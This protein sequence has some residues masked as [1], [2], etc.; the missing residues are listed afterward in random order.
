MSF[1]NLA[2]NISKS[3][4]T[5]STNNTNT[6]S[7]INSTSHTHSQ[8]NNDNDYDNRKDLRTPSSPLATF[9]TSDIPASPKPILSNILK[10]NLEST[11]SII[12]PILTKD[13]NITSSPH[14][15][16]SKTDLIELFDK[17]DVKKDADKDKDGENN[18]NN[19]KLSHEDDE[20]HETKL[21]KMTS[22]NEDDEPIEEKSSKPQTIQKVSASSHLSIGIQPYNPEEIITG[23]S[24][25]QDNS[26]ENEIE[27]GEEE[28]AKVQEDATQNE[29]VNAIQQKDT[30]ENVDVNAVQQK[31]TE[32]E[33]VST[34]QEDTTKNEVASTLGNQT[35]AN[36]NSNDGQEKTKVD[37]EIVDLVGNTEEQTG[38]E[39]YQI[40]PVGTSGESID[41]KE[42]HKKSK[43]NINSSE[44]HQQSHKPF[45]FQTF[46]AQL[47]KKSADPIVRYIRSFLASYIKQGHTFTAEQRIKIIK[48]FKLFMNEKFLLYEPFSSMDSI[49]LENSREGLEKLIMN[50]IHDL[51]FPPDIV[52]SSPNVYIPESFQV[53]LNKDKE[54]KKQLEK[55]DYLK[56]DHLEINSDLNSIK[57]KDDLTFLEYACQELTKINNYRAPRDKIIC[58]LNSC[59]IIFSFLKLTKKETNADSFIPILILVI[60]KSKIDDLHSN[61]SYIKNFR[62]PEWLLHGET[63]YY[64]ASIEG[65][66]NFIENLTVE[67][68]T[69]TKEEED[70]LNTLKEIFIDLDPKVL[71]EQLIENKG[72]LNEACIYLSSF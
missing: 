27:D 65:A 24:T 10:T 3:T 54:F 22:D 40:E 48:D 15:P 57:V 14:R 62:G 11:S 39:E 35:E 1:N 69:L 71:K 4:P 47:R 25:N 19:E 46:L 12:Q 26:K 29:G 51:C 45:D 59:K 61:I 6:T 36:S 66:I 64:M 2:F 44:Q 32:N 38:V 16:D 8:N 68:I 30:I 50:R 34:Q 13:E 28:V 53:D 41:N 20:E 63:S 33:E 56:A 52:K 5:T 42:D 70:N 67:D 7:S 43:F 58:I 72:D 21:E 60:M 17:F 9:T 23:S 55:Y 31:H 49:D 18:L 37:G